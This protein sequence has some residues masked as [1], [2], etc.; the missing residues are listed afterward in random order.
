MSTQPTDDE[1]FDLVAGEALVERSRLTRGAALADLGIA[2]LDVI[3]ILFAVE[4]RFGIQVEE[5]A[6]DGCS[7]VGDLIDRLKVAP[8]APA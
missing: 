3:S 2:S 6:L 7:T 5:N 1:L 4:D 8:S